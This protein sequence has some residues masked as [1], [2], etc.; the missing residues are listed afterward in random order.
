MEKQKK[1]DSEL[2]F[3]HDAETASE[4]YGFSDSEFDA[5]C[6]RQ[7]ELMEPGKIQ[8]K[9]ASEVVEDVMGLPKKELALFV[10][11]AIKKHLDMM[12][13][14]QQAKGM[15]AVMKAMGGGRK[16]Q[17]AEPEDKTPPLDKEMFG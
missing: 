7:N 8:G 5:A 12:Q 4:A 10:H 1:M 15:A 3:R 13:M 2:V 16:Q 9:K 6:E 11:T 17:D 14:L